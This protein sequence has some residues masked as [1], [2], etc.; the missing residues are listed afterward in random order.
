MKTW[1][2]LLTCAQHKDYK[3]LKRGQLR[4]SIP[5]IQE[6]CSWY[7]GFRKVVPTKDQIFQVIEWLRNPNGK[8]S[9]NGCAQD[10]AHDTKA[11]MIATTK[12]TQGM[13]I[14]ILNYGL[15]QDSKNYESNNESNDEKVTKATREQRQPDNIN[16]NEK[17]EKND[18]KDYSLEIEN[19]RQRYS[20]DTL[21]LI[22]DY[23]AILRTTRVSNKI[24]LSVEHKIYA[25]M[26]KYP[27]VVVKYACKTVISKPDLHSK[28]ENY[29]F[30]IL[31]NTPAD[32]AHRILSKP[33]ESPTPKRRET[34]AEVVDRIFKEL[35]VNVNG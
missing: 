1:V 21:N 24:S 31:R 23:L 4:T 10:C 7:V 3:G 13:V 20:S 18:N 19:F 11:T 32:E 26:N 9:R 2:Y 35:E 29:L 16:K 25:E 34:K 5:E 22:H 6:A 28:K 33:S 27:E 12:A 8:I 14:T 17:N 30:G 15:Y